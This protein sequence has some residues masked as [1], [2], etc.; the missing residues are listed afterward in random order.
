MI[1]SASA[2][3]RLQRL[4][5]RSIPRPLLRAA[6]PF[7]WLWAHRRHERTPLVL[8]GLVSLFSLGAR[9]WWLN[10]PTNSH[11]QS[12]L[13]FDEQYYV[14]AARVILGIHP[15]GT[16]LNAALG[17]DPNAEHPPLAKLL[18]A[19][20]IRIFGD[21][22]WG[23]RLFPILFG[24]IGLLA[25]YWM[26]RSAG[27]NKWLSLGAASLFAVDNLMMVQGR[28]A[29]V[30]IFTITFMLVA[31]GLYLRERYV[32]AGI[33]MG[34]GL[35]TKL[36][37]FDL[38]PIFILLEIGR[39]LIK[40]REDIRS[41]WR[42]AKARV[43]PLL[44]FVGVGLISYLALLYVLDLISSPIGGP[45]DCPTN[46]AG[47]HNPLE[48]TFFMLCYAGHLTAP[49][50]PTGIASYPWQW[51]L[52]EAPINYYTVNNNISSGGHV[53][54]THPIVAFQGVMNPAI[55]FLALPGFALA[56]RNMFVE[57]D[58][59]SFLIVAW[60]L[61]TFL[62]F[63]LAAAPAGSR[64]NRI[65]YLYYMVIV[66][67]GVFMA[68]AT[69]LGRRYLPVAALLGYVPILGY[70]FVTLYPFRTWSGS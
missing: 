22:A 13:I 28:I 49:Q 64:G 11:G 59:M 58:T 57:R 67:P 50:G 39:V 51:L 70:W 52:N 69:L 21:N 63:V 43:V 1:A 53:V 36:F 29:I 16:Y 46:P 60:L 31:A 15:T 18:I 42:I 68:V 7:R 25:M 12:A 5:P 24:T 14:N 40:Q 47:F 4:L 23:W 66:L 17:H 38:I 48:H 34:I 62:P 32:L 35:C 30:E 27:G 2:A 6:W 56:V 55:I 20:G 44:K 9:L 45:G 65:S 54:A 33:T 26:V 3:T 61:G 8:L 10:K 37:A 41:R 19:L